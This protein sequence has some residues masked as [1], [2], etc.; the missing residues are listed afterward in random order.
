MDLEGSTDK[1]GHAPFPISHTSSVKLR[2][3]RGFYHP[4]LPLPRSL[5]RVSGPESP[6]PGSACAKSTRPKGHLPHEVSPQPHP[7]AVIS[8]L[9]IPEVPLLKISRIMNTSYT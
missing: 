8:V 2:S 7:E 1:T 5:C 3:S 9:S 6:S 4:V